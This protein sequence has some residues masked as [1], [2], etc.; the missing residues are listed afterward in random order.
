MPSVPGCFTRLLVHYEDDTPIQVEDRLV[1]PA[2]APDYLDQDFTALTP[3]DY[4]TR[5]A[6]LVRGEHVVEA[7]LASPE[8][9]RLLR[10]TAVSPAC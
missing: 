8:E 7:V 6:P 5:V 9:C 1:N 2:E 3:N 10:S 4:L